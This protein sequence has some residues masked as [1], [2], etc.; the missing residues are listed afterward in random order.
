MFL[1]PTARS[2]VRIGNFCS[3]AKNV[4]ILCHAN[5]PT[6]LP[7]TY[8]FRTLLTRQS[9]PFSDDGGINFDAV[10]KGSID[11]GHDVWIGE[12]AIILSGSV[13]GTG[14]VIG[15]GA[16]VRGDIPPYAVVIG[17]PGQIVRLRFPEEYVGRLL[18][19]RW[20]DLPDAE[21]ASLD[22]AFYQKDISFFL[23]CVAEAWKRCLS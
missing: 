19:S 7:S 6:D 12:S 21:I 16:V 22:D 2:P 17:N 18:A 23:D 4:R 20:W 8:P 1:N 15:A 11:I 14:A 3:I 9:M 5:H 10:T 13:I